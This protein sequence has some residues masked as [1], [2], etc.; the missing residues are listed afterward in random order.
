MSKQRGKKWTG[1]VRPVVQAAFVVF[2]LVA[3]IRHNTAAVETPSTHAY[4]PFGVIASLWPLVTTGQFAPKIHLSSAVLGGAAI[5]SAFLVGGAFCGWVCPLGGLGD[6]LE[7]LR[8]KLRIRERVVPAKLDR[9][10]RYGRFLVLIGIIYATATTAKLWF[11]DFDPYYTIFSLSWIFEFD[12]AA[13]WPAYLVSLAVIGGS[14][15]IP[16]VWCRYL[17]PLGG[18]LSLVQRVS[19]IKVR[20]S[21][22]VCIHCKRCDRVCPTRLAVSIGGAVATNCVMCLRCTDTC[23][24]PGALVVAL[25]GYEKTDKA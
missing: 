18:L 9:V 22:P 6:A 20:R 16:R 5:L 7:W 8:R 14:L 3:A 21:A 13:S 25:P 15:F 24:A 23:P 17:C 1:L 4:C 2:I 12:L 10:L 11:A 19:P